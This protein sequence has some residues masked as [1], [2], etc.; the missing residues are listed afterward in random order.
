MGHQIQTEF[1]SATDELY[2]YSNSQNQKDSNT[3]SNS[4]SFMGLDNISKYT[5]ATYTNPNQQQRTIV[6]SS[7]KVRNHHQQNLI[8]EPTSNSEFTQ[9]SCSRT[10]KVR[11]RPILKGDKYPQYSKNIIYHVKNL[12][13]T[14]SEIN[15]LAESQG[16][17]EYG[18][19]IKSNEYAIKIAIELVSGAASL[20]K[21]R[22]LKAWASAEDLGG[23]RLDWSDTNIK[24]EVSLVIPSTSDKKIYLYH[25]MGD[26]YG[27]EYNV[28]AKTLSRWLSWFTSK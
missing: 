6:E 10:Q 19:V 1:T 4:K 24:K 17:D 16:E 22:F 11:P 18:E 14:I 28:S 12:E 15:G 25:E 26:E 3:S 21:N 5:G 13:Q 8:T 23:V 20:I 9:S 2:D 7:G 27:I